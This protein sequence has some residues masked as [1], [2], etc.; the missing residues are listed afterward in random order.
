MNTLRVRIDP[1]RCVG[2]GRCA[3]LAAG[4]I[5][6]D[7]DTNKAVYDPEA[8]ETAEPKELFAAA[9]ACPTQAIIIEQFGRRLY[10]Q[11]IEPMP[12]DI[13]KEIAAALAEQE[14]AENKRKR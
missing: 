7:E 13:A 3:V 12:A 9:R 2:F 10:P 4:V 14:E 8:G 11:I 6:I 5:T 1:N